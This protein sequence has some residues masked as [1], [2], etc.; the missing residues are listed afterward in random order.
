[1]QRDKPKLT[2]VWRAL[3]EA[4]FGAER[5]LNLRESLPSA[6]EAR[7]RA[8]VWIRARQMTSAKEVLVIT[9]R[10]NQSVGGIGVVRKEILKMLPSLRRR[11]VVENWK[12]H[13]PGSIVVRIAPMSALLEAPRRRR[14]SGANDQGSVDA[15]GLEGLQ[16]NTLTLLRQLALQNLALLGI[17][18]SEAFLKKEMQRTFSA[19]MLGIP[20]TG[21]RERALCDAILKAIDEVS[22]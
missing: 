22:E 5:T 12:E 20:E 13:S 18:D 19:M 17:T 6:A 2:A 10:G 9:G 16:Q 15:P 11:G 21:D 3:D 7:S 1:M 4:A 8:E 14:D